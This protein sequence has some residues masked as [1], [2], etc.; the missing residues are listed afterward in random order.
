MARLIRQSPQIGVPAVF[1]HVL[2][3][4]QTTEAPAMNKAATKQQALSRNVARFL[5][6]G[7]AASRVGSRA[8]EGSLRLLLDL[9]ADRNPQAP[10][11]FG[12][13]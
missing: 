10:E 7:D 6:R 3:S 4:P 2:Q 13:C 12:S 9:S 5:I 11:A 1:S 8:T